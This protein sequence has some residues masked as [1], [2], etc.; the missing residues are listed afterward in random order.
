MSL[1]QDSDLTDMRDAL[2]VSI[3]NVLNDMDEEDEADMAFYHVIMNLLGSLSQETM[4]V[5]AKMIRKMQSRC[6]Y[7][8]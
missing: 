8:S 4:D 3:E 2:I 5:K 6:T 7:T 1:L